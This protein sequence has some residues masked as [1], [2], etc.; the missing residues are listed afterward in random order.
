MTTAQCK[1]FQREKI[2]TI[3][4]SGRGNYAFKLHKQAAAPMIS[5]LVKNYTFVSLEFCDIVLP[6]LETGRGG[7]HDVG[8]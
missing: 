8:A 5:S 7:F 4:I 3:C 6:N 2:F 1:S